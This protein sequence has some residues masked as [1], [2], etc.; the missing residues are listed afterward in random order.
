MHL[1]I[2]VF[3]YIT[4]FSLKLAFFLKT[5][6]VISL[7]LNKVIENEETSLIHK[8]D[9]K[10]QYETFNFGCFYLFSSIMDQI[11]MLQFT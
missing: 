4:I 1:N 2:I 6:L 7:K 5:K 8:E 3:L 10:A 11:V 9:R